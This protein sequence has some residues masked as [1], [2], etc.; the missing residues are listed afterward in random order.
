MTIIN[1][2]DDSVKAKMAQ[3]RNETVR[4]ISGLS[5]DYFIAIPKKSPKRKD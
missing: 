3:F 4:D 1:K 2:N 5:S